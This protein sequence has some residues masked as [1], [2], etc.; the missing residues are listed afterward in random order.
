[1]PSL[2]RYID[3]TMK[4]IRLI[5]LLPAPHENAPLQS[6]MIHATVG[7]V[8]YEALSY[9]WGDSIGKA[10]L[11]ITYVG[12]NL[13]RQEMDYITT[14]TIGANLD[15]ALRHIRKHSSEVVIWVGGICINQ[16]D[17]VEK[18]SQVRLMALIYREAA[19]ILI[20]LGPADE[21]SDAAM[22]AFHSIGTAAGQFAF[23]DEKQ[24]HNGEVDLLFTM[25]SDETCEETT[26]DEK[27]Q[28]TRKMLDKISGAG[29]SAGVDAFPPSDVADLLT[30][31]WWSRVW[32][33]QEFLVATKA[34]FIYGHKRISEATFDRAVNV[35]F[36]YSNYLIG[37]G[38]GQDLNATIYEKALMTARPPDQALHL[39]SRKTSSHRG[40][41]LMSSMGTLYDQEKFMINATDPRDRGFALLNIVE[42]DLGLQPDYNLTCPEAYIQVSSAMLGS[43]QIGLLSYCRPH[44]NELCLLSWVVDWTT[45]VGHYLDPLERVLAGLSSSVY[46][47]PEHE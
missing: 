9:V 35:Y 44:L 6:R 19:I 29:S 30:R 37:R 15:A 46:P 17:K 43:G 31:S 38:T 14:T 3:S 5:I 12:Q 45:E 20:W 25:T 16:S 2:Y 36:G 8:K 4:E 24:G 28:A 34:I 33:L 39:F 7:T 27:S 40:S 13:A 1:M 22:E 21:C 32:V 10:C 41:S 47:E 23:E 18:S 11:A 26:V 42:D